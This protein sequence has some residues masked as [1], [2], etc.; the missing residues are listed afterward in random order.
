VVTRV[1]AGLF[2]I[3]SFTNRVR[4]DHVDAFPRADVNAT[5]AQ[6]AFGLVDMDELF[7]FDRAQ[8]VVSVNLY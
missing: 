3:V 1:G 5:F 7:W 6:D 8:E 2:S 4:R